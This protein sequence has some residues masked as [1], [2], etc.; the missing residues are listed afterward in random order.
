LRDNF[1]QEPDPGPGLRI[2]QDVFRNRVAQQ[3]DTKMPQHTID[4][5]LTLPSGISLKRQS[6]GVM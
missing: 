3:N 6:W 2:S 5:N 1:I 4:F